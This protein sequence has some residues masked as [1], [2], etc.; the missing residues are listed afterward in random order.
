MVRTKAII[1]VVER[2]EINKKI[3]MTVRIASMSLNR[4]LVET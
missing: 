4:S 3:E 2:Q 1:A